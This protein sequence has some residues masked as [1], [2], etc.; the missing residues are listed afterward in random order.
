M[1]D[2]LATGLLRAKATPA[3]CE[4]CGSATHPRDVV[5]LDNGFRASYLC[6]GVAWMDDIPGLQV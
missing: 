1:P 2:P 4:M 5:P 3:I 6:C